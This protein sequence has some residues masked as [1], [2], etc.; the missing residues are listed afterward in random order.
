MSFLKFESVFSNS[1]Y[2]SKRI[3]FRKRKK[4]LVK[5]KTNSNITLVQ[6]AKR[7]LQFK[8]HILLR[9]SFGLIILVITELRISRWYMNPGLWPH[10]F[11]FWRDKYFVSFTGRMRSHLKC[12]DSAFLEDLR[13]FLKKT[14][15][16]WKHH[17]CG[18]IVF[19]PKGWNFNARAVPLILFQFINNS[20][21][22]FLQLLYRP[23]L[24]KFPKNYINLKQTW[25]MDLVWW[26]KLWRGGLV[27]AW[28]LQSLSKC[29]KGEKNRLF[30]GALSSSVVR[31]NWKKLWFWLVYSRWSTPIKV[32]KHPVF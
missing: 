10:I 17:T 1:Q 2:H 22:N 12:N 7:C 3:T 28:F 31:S 24:N 25:L 16:Q 6:W 32:S 15:K 13:I 11:A 20:N 8:L 18:M 29:E 5:I 26:C 23:H 21:L 14:R 30:E 27:M 9:P 4:Q 19:A